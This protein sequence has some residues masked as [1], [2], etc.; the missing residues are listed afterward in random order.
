MFIWAHIK[1]EL[2]FQ[3]LIQDIEFKRLNH[4]DV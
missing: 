4:N 2:Y 1:I 3:Y